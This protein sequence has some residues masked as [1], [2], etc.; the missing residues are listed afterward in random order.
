MSSSDTRIIKYYLPQWIISPKNTLI[1]HITVFVYPH[2]HNK[3]KRI[4]RYI[5]N[6][7][8]RSTVLAY[9]VIWK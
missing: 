5:E 6:S 8:L 4:N 7:R 9:R 1:F 2:T 3:Y